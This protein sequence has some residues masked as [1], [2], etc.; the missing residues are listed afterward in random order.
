MVE[1]LAQSG[2]ALFY[3]LV[4]DAGFA[5]STVGRRCADHF[6]EFV[7]Q[8]GRGKV[9]IV[10]ARRFAVRCSAVSII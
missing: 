9:V 8:E 1:D 2:T 5:R 3:D 10:R 6:G 7:F 4:G